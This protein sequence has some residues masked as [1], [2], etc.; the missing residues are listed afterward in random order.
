M[1]GLALLT[2]SRDPSPKIELRSCGVTGDERATT[3]S[4][5]KSQWST[6]TIFGIIDILAFARCSFPPLLQ[7]G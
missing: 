1:L 4:L 7:D 2:R 3:N 6:A 5:S